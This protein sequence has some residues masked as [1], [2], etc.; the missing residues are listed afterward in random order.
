MNNLYFMFATGK[1]VS[2]FAN[3]FKIYM[4]IRQ[5]VSLLLHVL[6]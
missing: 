4:F 2:A 5:A 1:R 6:T 3:I